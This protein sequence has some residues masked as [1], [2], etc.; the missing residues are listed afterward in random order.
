MKKLTFSITVRAP[1]DVVWRKML[2][3]E[4]CGEWTAVF[5]EGS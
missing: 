4:T 5:T 1:R 3:R 2:E